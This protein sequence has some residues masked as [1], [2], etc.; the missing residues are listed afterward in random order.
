[1]LKLNVGEQK[2]EIKHWK[3]Q[4]YIDVKAGVQ[5]ITADITH[6]KNN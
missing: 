4:C 6:M 5:G 2:D 1:M 3:E